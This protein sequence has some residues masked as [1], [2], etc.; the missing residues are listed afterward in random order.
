[1]FANQQHTH[2]GVRVPVDYFV[3]VEGPDRDAAAEARSNVTNDVDF[4]FVE[5][6][7]L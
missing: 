4:L 2:T 1:M 3:V 7:S 5:F 6:C